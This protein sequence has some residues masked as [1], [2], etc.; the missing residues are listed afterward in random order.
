MVMVS[1]SMLLK[2]GS[3]TV[4]VVNVVGRAAEATTAAPA[5]AAEEDAADGVAED[6]QAA[7]SRTRSRAQLRV[8]R[9]MKNLL[10]RHI[11]AIGEG[12]TI[13]D[14]ACHLA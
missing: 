10:Q 3:L 9:V 1:A 13:R 6:L 4:A 11:F 12:N 14:E 5:G 8:G 7:S 2:E